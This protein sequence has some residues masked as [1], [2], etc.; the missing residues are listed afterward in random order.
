MVLHLALT[1]MLTLLGKIPQRAFPAGALPLY[2]FAPEPFIA[3]V[4]T[5]R[6]AS[7]DVRL[8]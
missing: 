6:A 7:V 1:V 5:L 4:T 8:R 3:R 2:L